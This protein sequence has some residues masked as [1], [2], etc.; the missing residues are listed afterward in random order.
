[1]LQKL[2]LN[3]FQSFVMSPEIIAVASA[4]IVTPMLLGSIEGLIERV[5][6]L[7]DHITIALIVVGFVVF[8]IA[9]KLHGIPKFII[10]GIAGGLLIT[11]INPF[12]QEQF[13]KVKVA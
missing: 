8:I 9:S 12:I 6:L 7:K 4:V 3:E 10:I 13:K 11:G 2:K 5:P 1:M